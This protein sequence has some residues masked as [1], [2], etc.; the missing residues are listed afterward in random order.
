MNSPESVRILCV[1]DE[2]HVLKSLQRVFLD[3][4]VA[5]LTAGGADEGLRLLEEEPSVRVVLSDY[6][7]PGRDGVDFLREVCRRWP[8]KVRMVLSGYADAPTII[9]AINEGKIYKFIAKPWDDDELRQA[10]G[11]ALEF[12]ELQEENRLLAEKLRNSN[13][14]LQKLNR[15]LAELLQAR[16]ETLRFQG[17]A[18][19]SVR[20]I[21]DALPVGMLGI[22]DERGEVVQCNELAARLLAVGKGDLL[23]RDMRRVLPRSL[24]EFIDRIKPDGK[25]YQDILPEAGPA[26]CR[27]LGVYMQNDDGT[28][29]GVIVVLEARS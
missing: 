5:V 24:V 26:G 7:M 19:E 15:R 21:M 11:K 18:L 25:L 14:K 10:I 4:P 9:A 3:E 12:Y 8:D 1:D 20:F 16:N 29:Q 28:Q 22:D 23:M 6:R 13:R 27:V 17:R 2:P